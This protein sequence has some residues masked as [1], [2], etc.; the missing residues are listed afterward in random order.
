[1]RI[2]LLCHQFPPLNKVGSLRAFAFAKYLPGSGHDV[3]V[4]TT[5]KTCLDGDADLELG[6]GEFELYRAPYLPRFVR[7]SSGDKDRSSSGR[8]RL[9]ALKK[10]LGFVRRNVLGNLM[11]VHDF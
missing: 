8:G 3:T 7:R 1:M 6:G 9:A 4:L 5:E 2:L 10:V 11:D